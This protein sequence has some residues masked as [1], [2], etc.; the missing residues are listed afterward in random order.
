MKSQMLPE[1]SGY[2]EFKSEVQVANGSRLDFRVSGNGLP[3]CF[4]EVKS[5]T[6]RQGDVAL[7]PDAVTCRYETWA[8]TSGSIGKPETVGLS[9]RTLL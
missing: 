6:L 5:V 9:Q 4:V 7:F 8:A 3:D 2:G 1:F